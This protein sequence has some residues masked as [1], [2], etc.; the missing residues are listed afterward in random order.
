VKQSFLIQSL[1]AL[2][3]AT[4]PAVC[5]AEAP[6]PA[7][8]FS[9]DQYRWAVN[10]INGPLEALMAHGIIESIARDDSSF[11]L[12]AGDAW[13][14]L[15][16]SQAGDILDKLSRARLITG[17]SPLVTVEQGS[18]G[19][20]LGRATWNSIQVLVPGEGYVEYSPDARIPESTAY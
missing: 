15:G 18:T 11:Q 20:V 12:Q 17:H 9:Q 8:A 16:F 1:L 4:A 19:T 3:L 10:W 14:R 13:A 6:P 7:D 5:G 2:A